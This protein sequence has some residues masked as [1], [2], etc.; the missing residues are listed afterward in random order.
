MRC[1]SVVLFIGFLFVLPSCKYFK[2]GEKGKTMAFM[3]AQAD[4]IKLADSL[5]KVHIL[6][7][8]QKADSVRKAEEERLALEA[9]LKYNIIVGSFL[10]PEYAKTFAD[11]YRKEGYD[12]KIIQKEGSKYQLVAVEAFNSFR[13]ATDRLS[14]FQDTVQ[15]E[16]W[17]Y[18]KK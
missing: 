8:N 5:E 6:L 18:V 11:G 9:S 1:L 15:F 3:M 14:K 10:T 12:P 7:M 16:A 17:M 4:S 13:K 2:K